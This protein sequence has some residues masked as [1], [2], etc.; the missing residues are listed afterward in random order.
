MEV[1]DDA[2]RADGVCLTDLTAKLVET[3]NL[4][5]SS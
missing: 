4:S 2:V 5:S 1:E 3:G